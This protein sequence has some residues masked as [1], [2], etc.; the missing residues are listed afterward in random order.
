MLTHVWGLMA[1]P[2]REWKQMHDEHETVFHLYA[3]HVLILSAVPVVCS[4][5]GTT[6]FGWGLVLN[7]PFS[8]ACWMR[9]T[10]AS[11]SIW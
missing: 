7:G 6:Q 10:Q 4:F 11:Y 5:I 8:L 9:F 2:Q 1:H 3:H